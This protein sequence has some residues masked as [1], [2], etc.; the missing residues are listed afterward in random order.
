MR[1]FAIA[2]TALL[3]SSCGTNA[4]DAN[5][6]VGIFG[7]ENLGGLWVAVARRGAGFANRAAMSARICNVSSTR[8]IKV[9][10]AP[11]TTTSAPPPFT[12]TIAR[13]QCACIARPA[14]LIVQNIDAAQ[15]AFSGVY[16]WMSARACAPVAAPA[17]LPPA[18][19]GGVRTE[20][21]CQPLSPAGDVNA[22]VCTA[23][24]PSV[25]VKR[26]CFDDGWVHVA[27]GNPY[28]TRFVT[29][30]L[31]GKLYRTP[32][33]QYDI[34][35]SYIAKGCIDVANA[36]NVWFN[37]VGDANFTAGNVDRITFTV[38]TKL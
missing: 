15:E 9:A 1:L 22:A 10:S 31:D 6:R 5:R 29:L 32:A 37:V 18:P 3:I 8:P 26:L 24:L 35:W 20:A 17:V 25:G 38:H 12:D 2:A 11:T 21:K 16:E 13:G 33:V 19:S 30:F 28:P 34:R 36:R 27:A 14:S 7:N 23:P 4:A